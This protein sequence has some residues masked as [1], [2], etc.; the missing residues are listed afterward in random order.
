MKI[1]YYEPYVLFKNNSKSISFLNLANGLK[2]EYNNNFSF[3]K[4]LKRGKNNC[5]IIEHSEHNNILLK[6]IAF[7]LEKNFMG[8]FVEIPASKKILPYINPPIRVL[9][10][11]QKYLKERKILIGGDSVQKQLHKLTIHL[12]NIS[13]QNKNDFNHI[14]RHFDFIPQETKKYQN[15]TISLGFIKKYFLDGCFPNLKQIDIVCNSPLNHLKEIKDLIAFGNKIDLH[16]NILILFNDLIKEWHIIE[17]SS[18]NGTILKPI[19][20]EDFENNINYLLKHCT[21]KQMNLN[22]IFLLRDEIDLSRIEKYEL[23]LKKLGSAVYPFFDSNHEF[24]KNFVFIDEKSFINRS[25]NYSTIIR[26][27]TLNTYFFGKLIIDVNGFIF[28]NK[29]MAPLGNIFKDNIKHMIHNE[30]NNSKT[31]RL[32]RPKVKPCK[33]C[34]YSKI[35]PPISY[36]ELEM[37]RYN[38]CSIH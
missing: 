30:L 2:L 25:Y 20:Y 17:N 37:N 35:C 12:N 33:N 23:K 11:F 13:Q 1:L 21:N 24:I 29:N 3:N 19:I 16:V 10:V 26:N 22:P 5:F 32:V 15:K 6:R 14:S 34:I 7:E 38:L 31:W 9:E 36:L 27:E 28:S 4:I 8:G 18:L